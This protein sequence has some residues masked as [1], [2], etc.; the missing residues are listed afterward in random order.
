LRGVRVAEKS[1]SIQV[2]PDLA[3][4]E[5]H[6]SPPFKSHY[7]AILLELCDVP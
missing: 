1:L 4:I 6:D 3:C 7:E 2:S 5:P